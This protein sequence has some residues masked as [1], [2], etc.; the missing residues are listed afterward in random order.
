MES[1]TPW[2]LSRAPMPMPSTIFRFDQLK[3]AELLVEDGLVSFG[4]A[5]AY[6]K[7]SD[8]QRDNELGPDCRHSNSNQAWIAD[9]AVA[10][11][12]SMPTRTPWRVEIHKGYS[13]I[14]V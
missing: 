5:A 12:R 11:P 3:Y 4:P 7:L 6:S 14:N 9:R 1:I 2:T 8:A 13:A 10:T